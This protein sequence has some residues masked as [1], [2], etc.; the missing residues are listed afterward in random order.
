MVVLKISRKLARMN[1]TDMP[2]LEM[3][4]NEAAH[5]KTEERKLDRHVIW[6]VNSLSRKD[7][8]LEFNSAQFINMLWHWR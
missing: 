8:I 7:S 3:V 2:D 5:L 1:K 4:V 6:V